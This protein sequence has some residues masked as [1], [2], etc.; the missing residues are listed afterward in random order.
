MPFLLSHLPTLF[1]ASALTFGGMVPLYNAEFAI[2]E[3]GIPQRIASSKEAQTIMILSMGR[4]TTIGLALGTFYLQGKYE[5][6]DTLLLL[7][8]GYLGAIDA[9][10]CWKEGVPGKAWFRGLSGVVIATCGWCGIT[11]LG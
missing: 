5:V 10:V 7:L 2:R 11:A 9:Y 3:M 1:V 6:V 8:G 4:T